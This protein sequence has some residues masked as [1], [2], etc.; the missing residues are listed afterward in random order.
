M[1][2]LVSPLS[3]APPPAVTLRPAAPG[4]ASE[5]APLIYAAGPAL[6]DRLFGPTRSEALAFFQPLFAGT[7]SL[8]SHENGVVA[9]R[10]GKVVGLA[11]AV[12]AAGYHR[13]RAVPR[14]LL[15]RSPRFLLGLLPVAWAL[16]R[17]TASPPADSFYLGILAVA[18]DARGEGIGGLLLS[19]VSRR[20]QAA[21]CACVCLH[22]ERD[23][24]GARRFYAR[25]GFVVTHERETPGAARWGISGFVGM[26]REV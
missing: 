15:R 21:G 2:D 6:Y 17:S 12:P 13:G 22:A 26:R 20:A 1:P 5:A 23:N 8:F 9:V 4:D 19:D 18:P 16:R 24:A 14:L 25:A 7:G 10:A 11:L 3:D